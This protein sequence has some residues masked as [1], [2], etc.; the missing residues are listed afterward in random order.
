MNDSAVRSPVP[1]MMRTS[2]FPLASAQLLG[3]L[4]HLNRWLLARIIHERHVLDP[5]QGRCGGKVRLSSGEE[6]LRVDR[7]AGVAVREAARLGTRNTKKGLLREMV[8]PKM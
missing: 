7:W 1:V 2:E 4:S 6:P 8:N 3:W 5:S